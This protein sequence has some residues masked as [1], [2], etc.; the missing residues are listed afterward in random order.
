MNG[1]SGV[2]DGRVAATLRLEPCS[3]NPFTRVTAVAYALPAGGAVRLGIFDVAGR[4]IATL[5]DGVQP[6]GR[7]VASWDGRDASG[8]P[9]AAGVYLV[10]LESGGQVR[11]GKVLRTR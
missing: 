5:V 8:F 1:S 9:V 4:R 2:S 7:H 10:R 3:P 11:N 6:A